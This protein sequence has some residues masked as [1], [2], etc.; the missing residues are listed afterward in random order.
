MTVIEDSKIQSQTIDDIAPR[1]ELHINRRTNTGQMKYCKKLD[2]EPESQMILAL[3]NAQELANSI[4]DRTNE[5]QHCD[6]MAHSSQ[7]RAST[8]SESKLKRVHFADEVKNPGGKMLVKQDAC[9]HTVGTTKQGNSPNH[10]V[11]TEHCE[12]PKIR[13]HVV[14]TKTGLVI[15]CLTTKLH[16]QNVDAIVNLDDPLFMGK[17]K[18]AFSEELRKAVGLK[19]LQQCE[20]KVKACG[21]L[22]PGKLHF[23][24]AGEL[25][26]SKE[27]IIHVGKIIPITHD[28]NYYLYYRNMFLKIFLLANS[29]KIYSLAIS[30]YHCDL[31]DRFGTD[32][33]VCA[34]TQALKNFNHRFE[35]GLLRHLTLINLVH[36]DPN[37]VQNIT[38]A[39]NANG[40]CSQTNKIPVL[41]FFGKDSFLSNFYLCSFKYRNQYFTSVEQF[42]QSER[43]RF[44]GD[45]EIE[46]RIMN[47][48]EPR[49]IKRLAKDIKYLD[50]KAWN[51]IKKDLMVRAVIAKFSQNPT[52]KAA[53]LR[54]DNLH[55]AECN[56]FD[57]Y[58]GIGLP[59]THKDAD[60]PLRWTGENFLGKIL[61]QVRD[62]FSFTVRNCAIAQTPGDDSP[63]EQ[64]QDVS[65]EKQSVSS[66]EEATVYEIAGKIPLS[67]WQNMLRGCN[68]FQAIYKFLLENVLP[69]DVAEAKRI[70]ISADNFVIQDSL[71]YKV[72]H[73]KYSH[74]K[75]FQKVNLLLA[76]PSG[77]IRENLIWQT[78]YETAH[79]RV[80]RLYLTLKSTVYWKTLFSDIQRE[81]AKC[82]NCLLG[83]RSAPA[84]IPLSHYKM[85]AVG[86]VLFVD[87]LFLSESTDKL[88]G[89]TAKYLLVMIDGASCYCIACPLFDLTAQS[90]VTALAR[91][92]IAYFGLPS[93]ITVDSG[94]NF[95]A[96]MFTE[97]M[98]QFN[99]QHRTTC[100]A[101]H[102][103]LSILERRNREINAAIRKTLLKRN[104]EWL[105]ALPQIL[106]A[107]NNT[108]STVTKIS[109]SELFLARKVKFLSLNQLPEG[110]IDPF[111]DTLLSRSEDSQFA[112]DEA[113]YKQTENRQNADKYYKAK[114]LITYCK[115]ESVLLYYES[116]PKAEVDKLFPS[117]K[118]C[119]VVGVL[120]NNSYRLSDFHTGAV[121]MGRYHASRLKKAPA[122]IR[123]ETGTIIKTTTVPE[124]ITDDV[125]QNEQKRSTTDDER[126][127]RTK[128]SIK[129]LSAGETQSSGEPNQGSQIQLENHEEQQWYEI[130][131]IVRRRRNSSG[132]WL[133]LVKFKNAE[134]KWLPARD[135]SQTALDYFR[136]RIS[137]KKRKRAY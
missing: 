87:I 67:E 97:F 39:L 101:N 131:D 75:N 125:T 118:L 72:K 95:T 74:K 112:I 102:K 27:S 99:I 10:T 105:T 78:H 124:L 117:Y 3:G 60:N 66:H 55:L 100:V 15:K 11:G 44:F 17:C 43:A 37:V 14:I 6:A 81:I 16:Q 68:E 21:P 83:H 106:L 57:K 132:S 128:K 82:E 56:P 36:W 96:K 135:I 93:C 73:I 53:L 64:E 108:V 90:S 30:L 51:I 5:A 45:R 23:T 136:H 38:N 1:L 122:E 111:K 107:L 18:N 121:L 4:I 91:S 123:T 49:N 63:V 71:L 22:P 103:S 8:H 25:V 77:K 116:A 28:E 130:E 54:T 32:A 119:K 70:M 80:L 120:E 88:T 134:L 61:E 84:K 137:K 50:Y 104:E 126:P 29:L 52:L 110:Q 2:V 92:Y 114:G 31:A 69:D 13:D 12:T 7:Q 86:E 76:V 26:P 20:E 109:P 33:L 79:S 48:N 89:K 40:L 98:E 35:N 129:K 58:W 34:F 133:Y 85:K 94:S 42:Y 9:E 47:E 41:K 19:L 24:S 113:T 59:M 46:W 127:T 115:D 62:L 65:P